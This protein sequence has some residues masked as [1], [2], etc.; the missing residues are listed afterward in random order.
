MYQSE[1]GLEVK[2]QHVRWA[3]WYI[4]MCTLACVCEQRVCM[5]KHVGNQQTCSPMWSS[6]SL[7][8]WANPW[9][10]LTFGNHLLAGIEQRVYLLL[11]ICL[12]LTAIQS[13]IW[14]RALC[15]LVPI[16]VYVYCPLGMLSVFAWWQ[17]GLTW[18]WSSTW[19]SFFPAVG[20][21]GPVPFL[22]PLKTYRLYTVGTVTYI[23][24]I[25]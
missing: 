14:Y 4:D 13:A 21:R 19:Q 25:F 11:T 8:P 16:L 10:G 9:L 1:P 22:W 15:S 2:L 5:P 6:F 7:D 12:F 18:L 3:L 24:Y 17:P 23:S 20:W